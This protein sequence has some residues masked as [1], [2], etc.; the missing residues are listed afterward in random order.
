MA[1]Y[2]IYEY[3]YQ[4]PWQELSCRWQHIINSM[5]FGFSFNLYIHS[6]V[7]PHHGCNMFVYEPPNDRRRG[8]QKGRMWRI[9]H[10][11]VHM[12]KY[13]TL[14][15]SELK[16]IYSTCKCMLHKPDMGCISVSHWLYVSPTVWLSG[17]HVWSVFL[18]YQLSSPMAFPRLQSSM[19][20][21]QV[22]EVPSHT[23]PF[24][25]THL[26][27]EWLDKNGWKDRRKQFVLWCFIFKVWW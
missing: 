17:V 16:H 1:I 9:T 4:Y 12:Y 8:L 27:A 25:R 15:N 2:N 7:S 23:G 6:M 26:P 14:I 24:R 20:K 3:Q 10:M 11:F 21:W 18:C 5:Y 22:K 19:G 13:W